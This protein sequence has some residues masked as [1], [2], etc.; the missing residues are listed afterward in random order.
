L[1]EREGFEPAV[2]VHLSFAKIWPYM[3]H[4][5]RNILD[6]QPGR[7]GTRRGRE[8]RGTRAASYHTMDRF[9]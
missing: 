9:V 5:S 2:P 1:A 4:F 8:S 7:E 3:A 6:R